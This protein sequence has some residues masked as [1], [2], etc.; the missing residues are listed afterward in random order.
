MGLDSNLHHTR[1]E[2]QGTSWL[3][4]NIGAL[5]K[6]DAIAGGL[7]DMGNFLGIE[8]KGETEK[9]PILKALRGR[10]TKSGHTGGMISLGYEFTTRE[11]A[12]ARKF[13]FALMGSET[14]PFTQAA[15]AGVDSTALAFTAQVPSKAGYWYPLFYQGTHVHALTSVT[16]AGKEE[17]VDFEVDLKMGLIRFIVAQTANVTCVLTG[18]AIDA[19]HK[20]YLIGVQPRD[21][22]VYSG[23]WSVAAFDQDPNNNLVMR[24]EFFSGDLTVTQWPKVDHTGQSELKFQIDITHDNPVAFHRD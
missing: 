8:I 15:L 14:D 16:I 1:A 7:Q 11:F 18:P 3:A 12:D 23:Y 19:A 9:E 6:A 21:R 24:H 10:V 4:G 20:E 5:T 13:K 17:G 2:I 22:V